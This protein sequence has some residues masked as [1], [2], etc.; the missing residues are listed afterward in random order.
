MLWVLTLL[1]VVVC[2]NCSLQTTYVFVHLKHHFN[3]LFC[4]GSW[5]NQVRLFG[6]HR[7]LCQVVAVRSSTTGGDGTAFLNL[8]ESGE[9]AYTV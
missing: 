2:F 4:S 1:K 5:L 8:D 6:R 3:F 9:L 7:H